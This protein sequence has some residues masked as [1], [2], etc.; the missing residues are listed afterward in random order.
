L[1]TGRLLHRRAETT[2]QQYAEFLA[3]LD[4]FGH[5]PS[6]LKEEPPN[7]KHTP[8]DWESQKG[9]DPVVNV[10]WWDASELCEVA[11]EAPGA[12]GGVGAGGELRSR[13]PPALSVGHKFQK[14]GGKSY[15][16]LE[17]MGSGAFEWT[18]DW[19][20]KYPGSSAED[21]D[22]GERKKVVRGGV[23]LVEDAV[24]SAKATTRQAYF[25]TQRTRWVGFRCVQDL[26]EK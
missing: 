23:R 22:F 18:S 17:G 14:D 3:A 20:K 26:P 15:L 9:T 16:G 10:D 12:R 8:P 1:E 4:S 5:T 6:C 11:R 25:P 19:Y 21:A 7:K 13:R 2:V 24:E